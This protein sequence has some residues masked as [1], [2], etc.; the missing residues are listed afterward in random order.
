MINLFLISIRKGIYRPK[1]G[2]CAT[3]IPGAKNGT[4]GHCDDNRAPYESEIVTVNASSNNWGFC[5]LK[6]SKSKVP[7]QY[8]QEAE[9]TI[10]NYEKCNKYSKVVG[11]PLNGEYEMCAGNFEKKSKKVLSPQF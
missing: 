6:C 11:V 4:Y 8:L 2:W 7:S 5:D 1:V 9:L 10:M 3:C